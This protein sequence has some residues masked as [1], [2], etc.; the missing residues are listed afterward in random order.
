MAPIT[1]P[2]D[3]FSD[4]LERK[5]PWFMTYNGAGDPVSWTLHH[6]AW[7]IVGSAVG[8]AIGA[9]FGQAARGATIGAWIVVV[10]YLLR[11]ALGDGPLH[12]AQHGWSNFWVLSASQRNQWC[13]GIQVGWGTD[14]I[15]DVITPAALA[16]VI[17]MWGL[18]FGFLCW[19]ALNA[20]LIA[21]L[22]WRLR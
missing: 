21:Y 9:A 11:E 1:A 4:W 8:A 16:I 14:G 20:L 6:G 2:L 17:T 13:K 22:R 12:L 5:L 10:I 3:A 18:L 7:T 15:M 19:L